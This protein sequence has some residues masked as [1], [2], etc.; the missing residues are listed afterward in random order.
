[1]STRILLV[2]DHGIVR[3]GLRSVLEREEGLQ[4]VGEAEDGREA[5]GLVGELLPDII[6]MDITRCCTWT[7]LMP[8]QYRTIIFAVSELPASCGFPVCHHVG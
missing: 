1:M 2:D 7:L 5:F 3:E 6:I 4:V 8:R